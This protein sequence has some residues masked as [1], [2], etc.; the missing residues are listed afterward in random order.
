[1][2]YDNVFGESLV[3]P[4]WEYIK[5]MQQTPYYLEKERFIQQAI[6]EKNWIF[7]NG[8]KRV[9]DPLNRSDNDIAT[10]KTDTYAIGF[11]WKQ[12]CELDE[13][14]F[15][16]TV[17]ILRSE[18]IKEAMEYSDKTVWNE[19]YRPILNRNFHIHLY[20]KTLN[21]V[22]SRN[23]MDLLQTFYPQ[24]WYEVQSKPEYI[25]G[26]KIIDYKTSGKRLAILA[27]PKSDKCIGFSQNGAT[28]VHHT[29]LFQQ[30]MNFAKVFLKEPVVFDG[31]VLS[32]EYHDLRD[33]HYR[34]N[35]MRLTDSVHYVYDIIPWDQ[36]LARSFDQPLEQRRSVLEKTISM[37]HERGYLT[38]VKMIKYIRMHINPATGEN[39]DKLYARLQKAIEWGHEGLILKNPFKPYKCARSADWLKLRPSIVM[40]LRISKIYKHPNKDELYSVECKGYYEDY[41]IKVKVARGMKNHDR[42]YIWENREDLIGKHIEVTCASIGKLVDNSYHCLTLPSFVSLRPDLDQKE[43]FSD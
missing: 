7:I 41:H 14:I 15:N 8:L 37:A 1:M 12:F 16:K 38:N 24:Q 5:W 18:L 22:L 39:I 19:W 13:R 43:S 34:V 6:D 11:T 29:G 28:T 30:Y 17:G 3:R 36:Y 27:D 4:P 25:P 31:D 33:R 9:L 2:D 20:Y 21:K 32:E 10:Y 40:P 35:D 23:N 42:S 26:D